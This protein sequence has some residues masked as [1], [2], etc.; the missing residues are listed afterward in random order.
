MVIDI[1]YVKVKT[2]TID[3]TLRIDS[4]LSA[5][6]IEAEY[7]WVRGGKLLAGESSSPYT[8]QLTI[9]LLGSRDSTSL[10]IDDISDAGTKV[11]GITG[12]VKLYGVAPTNTQTRLA[13]NANVG[14]TVIKVVDDI[15]DWSAGD[16]IVLGPTEMVYTEFEKATIASISG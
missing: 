7:I 1:S 9:K 6:T 14:D 8:G 2:L 3:G 13:Q 16:E 15:S 5:V 4:S 11:L 12:E 10:I